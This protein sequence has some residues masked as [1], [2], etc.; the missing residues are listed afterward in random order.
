MAHLP[1]RSQAGGVRAQAL[2]RDEPAVLNVE[3]GTQTRGRCGNDARWTAQENA[4]A[5]SPT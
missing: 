3:Q 1:L 5:F 2:G 4:G